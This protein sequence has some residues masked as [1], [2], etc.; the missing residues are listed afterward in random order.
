[1][2]ISSCSGSPI[3]GPGSKLSKIVIFQV[4]CA[5][6]CLGNIKRIAQSHKLMC[7]I[8]KLLQNLLLHCFAFFAV[9]MSLNN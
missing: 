3:A 2:L 7:Q 9:T 4:D 5:L 8:F 1:M 6:N